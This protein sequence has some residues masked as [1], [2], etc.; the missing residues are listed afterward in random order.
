MAYD[1]ICK[2]HEIMKG[3]CPHLDLYALVDPNDYIILWFNM[4]TLHFSL[5]TFQF[6]VFYLPK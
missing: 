1:M 6:F 3:R 2:A 4:G 5:I